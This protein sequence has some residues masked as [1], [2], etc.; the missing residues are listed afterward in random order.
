VTLAETSVVA[1][2]SI[3]ANKLR[4]LLTML[5]IIIGVACVIT[6]V[7][8][9]TGAQRAVEERIN[10][11]GARLISVFGEQSY[12]RG[13]ATQQR[14][15]L[16]TADAEALMRD[17]TLLS[18]VV[19]EIEQS[20]QVKYGSQ[21]VRVSVIGTTP[22]YT[23]VNNYELLHG[24]MFTR[25]DDEARQRYA[26]IGYAIPG[27]LG[28][29]PAALIRQTLFVR[30]IPFEII[31]VLD[32]KGA[33]ASWND[34]DEQ[35][36]IPLATAQYRVFGSDKLRSITVRVADE[37]PLEQGMVDLERV[38]RREHRLAPGVDNDFRIRNRQEILETQQRMSEIFTY[39][40]ASIAGVSLLVGGIGIMNI[41][42][43][44]VTERTRE[45]GIRKALGATRREI[46]LQFLVEAL[47]L[48]LAGGAVGVALG[49]SLS[50][51]LS[52]LA[53]WN[54]IVSPS[55]ILLSFAF[56]AAVGLIFGLWPAR[57][58]ALLA[59]VE[60]LRHE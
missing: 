18:D 57:R 49:W 53:G 2:Q 46:L 6:M 9:G 41:M 31:G 43:V 29:H 30:G 52:S 60:A 11:L 35:I 13:V 8:L 42:L 7:A 34:P 55:A 39:L 15:D 38:L 1:F 50:A 23:E 47:V 24:R 56:S 16:T 44:S 20:L 5:G 22:T 58:A 19:P 45:I 36:L 14:V 27:L 33:A 21:N 25:G 12:Q 59:P 3:R 32:E 17:A 48:C 51:T 28:Q 4:A 37:L 10:S 40:L 54:T 26:V